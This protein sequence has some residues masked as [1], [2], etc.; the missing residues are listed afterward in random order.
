MCVKMVAILQER[1]TS[2]FAWWILPF[3]CHF[4]NLLSKISYRCFWLELNL[5][6]ELG[7]ESHGYESSGSFHQ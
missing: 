7:I 4:V 6:S 1:P 2:L 5:G 3:L